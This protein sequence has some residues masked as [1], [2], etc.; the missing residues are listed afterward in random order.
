MDK[1]EYKTLTI[2]LKK[3]AFSSRKIDG[4]SLSKE[5]NEFGENG[6]ELVSKI[7]SVTDG[8]TSQIVLVFKRKIM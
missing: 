7:D 1:F 3:A 2:A 5:L 8:W 6:W 4:E